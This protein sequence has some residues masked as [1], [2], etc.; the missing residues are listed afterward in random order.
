MVAEPEFTP[1]PGLLWFSEFVLLCD[2][3]PAPNLFYRDGRTALPDSLF[4]QSP[5]FRT[6]FVPAVAGFQ[7]KVQFLTITTLCAGLILRRG[8]CTKF[9]FLMWPCSVPD[10]FLAVTIFR[11]QFYGVQL[12]CAEFIS[13]C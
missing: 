8:P 11:R 2:H 5:R 4:L 7:Y 12:S 1:C 10:L 13:R 9:T 6:R 3:N